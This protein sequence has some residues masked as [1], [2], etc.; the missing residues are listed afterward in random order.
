[1]RPRGG[2]RGIKY[3]SRLRVDR[4]SAVSIPTNQIRTKIFERS[5][6]SG[7]SEK[8]HIRLEGSSAIHGKK[9]NHMMRRYQYI[10]CPIAGVCVLPDPP[11]AVLRPP[12]ISK[13]HA[14][15]SLNT[16]A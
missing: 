16:F 4:L 15:L 13:C 9:S 8:N 11:K 2:T 6:R 14:R 1:M 12:R 7:R 3:V 5:S 10:G